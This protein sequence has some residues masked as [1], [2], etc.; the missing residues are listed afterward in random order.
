M[1]KE[2]SRCRI[3]GNQNLELVIDLGMQALTGVFPNEN[4]NVEISP[5]ELVKC[6]EKGCGLLQLKHS[7]ELKKCM[8][9]IMD[10]EVV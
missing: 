1:F 6:N 3:C 5:L 9:K 2:I 8:V 10:I 7:N 4:E